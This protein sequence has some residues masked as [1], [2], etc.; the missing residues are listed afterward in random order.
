MSSAS[1]SAA[2]YGGD[3][4]NAIVLDLGSYSTR[5]GYAGDDFPKVIVPPYYA[6]DENSKLFFD[7]SLDFC[8]SKREIL[9]VTRE[10]LIE[11]WDGF[12][13]QLKHYF[14]KVMGIDYQEQPLLVTE[15]VWAPQEYR[16]RLVETL[17]T[18]FAFPALYLV[19]TPTCISFQQGRLSCLVV[20]LGHD[21]VSVVPVVDGICLLKNAMRTNYGGQFLN[22]HVQDLLESKF[23]EAD[24]VEK[25]KV[26]DKTG[27]A[28]PE[29]AQYTLRELPSDITESFNEYQRQ[30]TFTEIKELMLEAPEKKLHGL[31]ALKEYADEDHERTV[32]LPS[33]QLIQLCLERFELADALFDP[34][35]YPF[36]NAAFAA[37]YPPNNGELEI[38]GSYDDYRPLKRARKNDPETATPTPASENGD[39]VT[40][41][42]LSQL[43]SHALAS[44]DIDLRTSI[45]HN[46]IITGGVSLI[47]QLTERL[48]TELLN[49]NP[50]LKIRLHALGNANERMNQT[51]IGGSVLASLGTF[52]QMWV[53]KAEYDE[54]G[55]ERIFT[56]RFR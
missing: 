7:D 38:S 21:S 11:D 12:V 23:P 14:E 27:V 22:D 13:V 15:P 31:L 19:K 56:Q 9:R 37:Q 40:T 53:S 35:S 10:G 4:I 20:D 16:Q 3:E 34:A 46:I 44:V 28:Y 51:W 18:H 48:N 54:V 42:G 36:K 41:R 47:P 2:I 33:G 30:K 29:K 55:T 50:G 49:A 8:K 45:A 17:Y 5:I 25:Y 6:K 43:I 52:H 24:L 39:A 26:K 32:E 1:T